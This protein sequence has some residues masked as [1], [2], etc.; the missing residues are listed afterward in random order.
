MYDDFEG[1]EDWVLLALAENFEGLSARSKQRVRQLL[2]ESRTMQWIEGRNMHAGI[3]PAGERVLQHVAE[4]EAMEFRPGP[5]SCLPEGR[6]GNNKYLQRFR[7]RRRFCIGSFQS[8]EHIGPAVLCRKA[9]DG[10]SGTPARLGPK[11]GE[12]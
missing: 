10:K 4:A 1:L 6:A 3:A 8:R 12:R 9:T 11:L 2:I 5:G 7:H